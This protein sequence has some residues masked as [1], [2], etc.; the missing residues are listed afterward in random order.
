MPD[1]RAFFNRGPV[2]AIAHRGGGGMGPENSLV[3]MERSL[4]AGA[5][6]LEVDVR[7][8]RDGVFILHHDPT[9]IRVAG[10]SASPEEILSVELERIDLR[11]NWNPPEGIGSASVES[12]AEP[13]PLPT[14]RQAFAAFPEA[15]FSLDVK[16]PHLSVVRSLYELLHTEGAAERVLLG[17]FHGAVVREGRKLSPG[18]ATQATERELLSLY[19]RAMLGRRLPSKLPFQSIAVPEHWRGIPVAARHFIRAMRERGVCFSVWTVNDAQRIRRLLERGVDALV[20]DYPA[21]VVAVC[22]ELQG[23]DDP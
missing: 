22:T 14:L 20:T 4:A 21:R 6:V 18:I 12:P 9:L 2:R 23:A 1:S 19:T 11:E 3:A 15:R 8:T 7:C 16:L 17:S 10:L 5:D 13:V